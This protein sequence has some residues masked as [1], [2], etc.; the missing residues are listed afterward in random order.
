MQVEREDILDIYLEWLQNN[1]NHYYYFDKDACKL[2][3]KIQACDLS[4]E[5]GRDKM[6]DYY[7][8]FQEM[9]SE[10]PIKTVF[11]RKEITGIA[12]QDAEYSFCHNDNQTAVPYAIYLKL[13]GLQ[14]KERADKFWES[15]QTDVTKKWADSAK[16]E[17]I[18]LITLLDEEFMKMVTK[19]GNKMNGYPS[20]VRG[21]RLLCGVL[22]LYCCKEIFTMKPDASINRILILFSRGIAGMAMVYF[23]FRMLCEVFTLPR[24]RRIEKCRDEICGQR[25]LAKAKVNE[26]CRYLED[27]GKKIQL[28]KDFDEEFVN[29]LLE[30]VPY[31]ES[32]WQERYRK[33]TSANK[34]FPSARLKAGHFALILLTM[35]LMAFQTNEKIPVFYTAKAVLY[36][37]VGKFGDALE[38][39]YMEVYASDAYG[40]HQRAIQE[41]LL[42]QLTRDTEQGAERTVFNVSGWEQN[43]SGEPVITGEKED[44]SEIK[45]AASAVTLYY[46]N[47]KRT[48]D[49]Q[50]S[51]EGKDIRDKEGFAALGDWNSSTVWKNE[52][53]KLPAFTFLFDLNQEDMLIDLIHI[54]NGDL[55]SEENYKAGSRIKTLKIT[56]NETEYYVDLEDR[57]EPLGIN[58]PLPEQITPNLLKIEVKDIYVGEKDRKLYIAGFDFYKS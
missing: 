10:D 19:Y 53:E 58:V 15:M 16:R 57:F 8:I 20:V 50:G 11:V 46:P 38:H 56:A 37:A 27:M 49:I 36:N 25:S 41:N 43:E 7:L 17:E 1:L 55:T 44:G 4:T 23:L 33:C 52:E 47:Y 2:K 42:A 29:L 48:L 39:M 35:C 13:G 9:L 5:D 18:K 45:A 21:I 24:V 14:N 12:F 31:K 3:E 26:I 32:N 40:I 34:E 30:V 51:I 22:L 6:R 54:G 28:K